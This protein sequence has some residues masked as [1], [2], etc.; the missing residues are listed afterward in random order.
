VR[1]TASP[2]YVVVFLVSALLA[3]G[4]TF[5]VQWSLRASACR[6]FSKPGTY[7][8]HCDAAQYGDYEHGAYYLGY[9]S[10]AVHNL[11]GA[12]VLFLGNSRSQFEFSTDRVESY[13]RDHGLRY[14]LLGFGYGEPGE[15]PIRLIERYRFRPRALVINADGF[16][17]EGLTAPA[18]A[19]ITE[20]LAVRVEYFGKRIGPW[21]AAWVCELGPFRCAR[22]ARTIYRS[23]TTGRWIWA[24]LL[25]APE[26]TAATREI[27]QVMATD[28]YIEYFARVATRFR[29]RIGVRRECVVLTAAP[30]AFSETKTLVERLAARLAWPVI[31]PSVEGLATVDGSHLNMPSA[32]RW[33]AAVMKE[34]D[35]ALGTCASIGQAKQRETGMTR[36][37]P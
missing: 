12:D 37:I 23:S 33:S 18:K 7:L 24:N 25:A 31:Y 10:E 21:I 35:R 30:N 13:F 9:E 16:F 3:G 8:A 17:S 4:L 34:L 14:H 15:F 5:V 28:A 22:N 32:E 11:R 27:Q 36:T 19:V 2:S 1:T 6:S 29:K 26:H 20:S